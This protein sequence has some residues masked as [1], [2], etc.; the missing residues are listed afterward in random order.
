NNAVSEWRKAN[1]G[2]SPYRERENY[3]LDAYLS[4]DIS[5]AILNDP[6][7]SV[8]QRFRETVLSLYNGCKEKGGYTP[9]A[10]DFLDKMVGENF[11][12][13]ADIKVKE[14]FG[15]EIEPH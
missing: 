9:Q 13:V 5:T 15:V 3:D 11:Q 12:G 6:Q 10:A 2:Q 14:L 1:A 7:R 4:R 8:A